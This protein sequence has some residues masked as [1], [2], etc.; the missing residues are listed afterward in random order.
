M[1][2]NKINAERQKALIDNWY[3]A[4]QRGFLGQADRIWELFCEELR[5]E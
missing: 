3:T 2:D 1:Q 5:N 4:C